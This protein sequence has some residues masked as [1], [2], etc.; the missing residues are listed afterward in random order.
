MEPTITL[1]FGGDEPIPGGMAAMSEDDKQARIS[2]MQNFREALDAKDD[3]G[4][5][6]AFMA[7]WMFCESDCEGKGMGY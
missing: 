7:L 4:A 1:M 2:A 6:E 5:Y 3:E